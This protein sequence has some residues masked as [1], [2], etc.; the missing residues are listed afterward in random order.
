[1]VASRFSFYVKEPLQ[2]YVDDIVVSTDTSLWEDGLRCLHYLFQSEN[3][4]NKVF[5]SYFVHS[6]GVGAFL[7]F[8]IPAIALIAAMTLRAG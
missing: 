7:R 6:S 4:Q 1:M 2:M 8:Q 3:M 5:G